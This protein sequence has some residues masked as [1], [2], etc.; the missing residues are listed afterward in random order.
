[1]QCCIRMG[2]IST[3]GWRKS[4]ENKCDDKYSKFISLGFWQRL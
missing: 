4:K 1:M 3:S 2:D